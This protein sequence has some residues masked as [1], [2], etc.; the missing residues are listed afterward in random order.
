[1]ESVAIIIILIVWVSCLIGLCYTAT[2]FDREQRNRV[3]RQPVQT[4]RVIDSKYVKRPKSAMKTAAGSRPRNKNLRLSSIL[5]SGYQV[6][7]DV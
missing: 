7:N 5:Y 3:P 1:M 4:T 2:R 6:Y